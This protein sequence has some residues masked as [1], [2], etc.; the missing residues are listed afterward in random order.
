MTFP[1][2]LR[3]SLKNKKVHVDKAGK[4]RLHSLVYF[5]KYQ[6]AFQIIA[7]TKLFK[8]ICLK[9]QFNWKIWVIQVANKTL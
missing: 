1:S 3:S 2:A 4:L 6:H 9:G 7:A 8:H 5:D